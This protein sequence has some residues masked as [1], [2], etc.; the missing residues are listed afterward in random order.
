MSAVAYP[1]AQHGEEAFARMVRVPHHDIRRLSVLHYQ[2]I[3]SRLFI[4]AI[5]FHLA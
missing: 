3:L 4:F 5:G 2:I 1:S